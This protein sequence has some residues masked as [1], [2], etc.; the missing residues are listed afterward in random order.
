MI[1]QA[2]AASGVHPEA[3]K[4]RQNEHQPGDGKHTRDPGVGIVV[5]ELEIERGTRAGTGGE[6][7]PRIEHGLLR[8]AF[9]L[10]T[11]LGAHVT[12]VHRGLERH[13]AKLN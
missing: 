4:Q 11:H 2:A 7:L 10:A 6:P 5:E 8:I 3:G 12:L 1:A 9:E 13:N